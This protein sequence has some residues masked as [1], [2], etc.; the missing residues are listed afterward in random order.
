MCSKYITWNTEK[1]IFQGQDDLVK[2]LVLDV[3]Y[4]KQADEW[5]HLTTVRAFINPKEALEYYYTESLPRLISWSFFKYDAPEDMKISMKDLIDKLEV[6]YESNDVNLKNAKKLQNK[7]LEYLNKEEINIEEINKF[8]KEFEEINMDFGV[9]KLS[10]EYIG[11]ADGVIDIALSYGGL[12]L[13]DSEEPEV[14]LIKYLI[15]FD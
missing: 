1:Y 7:F 2:I 11:N 10:L 8:K 15:D 9:T 13:D 14:E 6:L 5:Y 4:E 3:E 12:Y